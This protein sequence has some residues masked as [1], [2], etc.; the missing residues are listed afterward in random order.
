MNLSKI[1][2]LVCQEY[3]LIARF[4][5]ILLCKLGTK[6]NT[7]P[8]FGTTVKPHSTSADCMKV[9]QNCYFCNNKL[10]YY[11][12]EILASTKSKAV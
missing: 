11:G 4:R 12:N 3:F 1:V 10:R 8:E 6:T 2:I 7:S 5:S 9:I